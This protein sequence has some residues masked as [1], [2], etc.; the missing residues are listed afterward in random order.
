[1]GN[2]QIWRGVELDDP[3]GILEGT[4]KKVRHIKF[5]NMEDVKKPGVK[6]LLRQAIAKFSS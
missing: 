3:K 6:S 1:M 5:E 4:G 2:L